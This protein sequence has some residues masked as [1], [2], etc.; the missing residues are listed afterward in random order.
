MVNIINK[1]TEEEHM[2]NTFIIYFDAILKFRATYEINFDFKKL[3]NCIV[4]FT[5]TQFN[6]CAKCT[7]Q[8]K[9]S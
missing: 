2:V 7:T 8:H 3:K 9:N 6:D 1:T 5:L 4:Q